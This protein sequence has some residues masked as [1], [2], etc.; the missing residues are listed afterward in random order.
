MPKEQYY[1]IRDS[2]E[3]LE[4][5]L[6]SYKDTYRKKKAKKILSLF[7]KLD[8]KAVLEL[9]CGGGAYSLAASRKGASEVV[10]LD[11]SP[12]RAKGAKINVQRDKFPFCEGIAAD[13]AR[14]PFK[15]KCFDVI[16]L[17]DVIEHIEADASF[18]RDIGRVL[19]NGGFIILS[20]QNSFSLNFWLEAP[21]Q[22][23]VLKN[24]EWMGWDTTHVRF[25]NPKTLFHL[26]SSCGF[27]VVNSSGTYFVPTFRSFLQRDFQ[28]LESC[29]NKINERL[30][31]SKS[32]FVN[33]LGWNIIYLCQKK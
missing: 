30:E 13:A 25:Y 32:P 33:S 18:L 3:F 19:C 15:D 29:S 12:V 21:V 31:R 11:I 23:Y 5:Y 20:T 14:L 7:P 2:S 24:R 10:S 22:R 8:G 28:V 4:F 1:Q 9:G 16:V 27:C 17:I 6:N 26:L